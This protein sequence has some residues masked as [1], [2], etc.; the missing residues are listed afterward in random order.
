M[1]YS[2]N[3]G[4]WNSVF[5]VPSVVVDKY[6]KLAGAD[7]LKLLLYLLRHGGE[8]FGEDK[9][10]SDLGF[11]EMGQ[12]EDAALFWIQRG[13]IRYSNEEK[14]ILAPKAVEDDVRPPVDTRAEDV[15][16]NT[17][18][19]VQ[20][21]L[22][23]APVKKAPER[24][25]PAAVDSREIA[26]RI[27][28]S[29]EIKALFSEAEKIYGRP[30]RPR[31]DQ[32]LIA[33]AD[34]YGLPIG[35]SL[36]LLKYCSKVEKMTPNYIQTVAADWVEQGID[37]VDKADARISALERQNSAERN[38]RSALEMTTGFTP[39]QRKYLNVWMNEWKFSEGMI[40]L[41]CNKTVD[42]LGKWTASYTNKILENWRLDGIS[43]PEAAN[44]PKQSAV[45]SSKNSSFN[46][47][48]LMSKIRSRYKK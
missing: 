1:N 10:R 23:D 19:Y 7:S 2:L 34:H 35:V 41:A 18:E 20:Q 44:A 27:N 26:S 37:T 6:I 48:D 42:Q 32:V 33:L 8:E 28:D 47:D 40:I 24:I 38:I 31:D 15:P 13:V 36:M 17:K 39:Q 45:Q 43:T 11:V 21:T 5:A 12:L 22:D 46:K 16:A 9:L 25:I 29:A 30:L 4:E 14:G 3:M